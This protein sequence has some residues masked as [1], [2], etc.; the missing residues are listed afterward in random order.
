M[1]L[2]V[3]KQGEAISIPADTYCILCSYIGPSFFIYLYLHGSEYLSIDRDHKTKMRA[4]RWQ[5][6]ALK[7]RKEV[8]NA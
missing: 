2:E 4:M 5:K 3:I 1:G 6:E 8:K 7:G